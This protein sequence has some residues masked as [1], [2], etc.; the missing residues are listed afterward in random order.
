MTSVTDALGWMAGAFYV[1]IALSIV[2]LFFFKI[3]PLV[4][5]KG[6]WDFWSLLRSI[7]VLGVLAILLGCVAVIT[8]DWI[9]S[10]VLDT[11]PR[12]R[13]ARE[14]D[15][16]TG[17]LIRL[18]I[19]SPYDASTASSAPFFGSG[20]TV[21]NSGV[22]PSAG[23]AGAAAPNLPPPPLK[24]NALELWAAAI[25]TKYN[26]SGKLSDNT[27][28]MARR[29]IPLG[30]TCDIAAVDSGYWPKQYEEWRLSCSR[31]N[32]RTS[33]PI[34][35]NGTAARGLTGGS[36]YGIDNP[37]TIYGT[38]TWPDGSYDPANGPE[39][40][41]APAAPSSNPQGGPTAPQPT[42]AGMVSHTVRAGENLAGIA[43]YYKLSVNTLVNANQQKYPQLQS[44]PNV[45]GVGWVLAIPG[46]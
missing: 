9:F 5:S 3:V 16:V 1:I 43:N 33:V 7:V 29:D 37:F 42:P 2:Y 38:G 10:Q 36:Y 41:P 34:T 13:M 24:A 20:P 17:S 28:V 27:Q 8:A 12:T 35:V 23:V 15:R 45:I 14:V 18:S 40:Q 39:N 4:L 32:F 19:D 22:L 11:L 21:N 44:N 25:Q 31:D 26:T 6:S 46:K 30:V